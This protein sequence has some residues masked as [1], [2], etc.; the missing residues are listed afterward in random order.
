MPI[1]AMI[2]LIQSVRRLD[3]ALQIDKLC[4]GML[5]AVTRFG[6]SA[7]PKKTIRAMIV[8]PDDTNASSIFPRKTLLGMFATARTFKITMAAA[9]GCSA[10]FAVALGIVTSVYMLPRT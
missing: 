4:D 9:H 5:L 3:A 8:A 7:I 2:S 1:M 10:K 6:Q